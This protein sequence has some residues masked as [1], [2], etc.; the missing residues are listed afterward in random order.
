MNLK[1]EDYEEYFD[2]FQTYLVEVN[3]R[4]QSMGR[5]WWRD[6]WESAEFINVGDK[7]YKFWDDDRIM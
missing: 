3:E 5:L 2:K 6:S 1:N 4:A 7:Q